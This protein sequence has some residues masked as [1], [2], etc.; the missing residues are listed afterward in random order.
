MRRKLYAR[1]SLKVSLTVIACVG[2]VLALAAALYLAKPAICARRTLAKMET[3]RIGGTT[4]VEAE[5]IAGQ[6]EAKPTGVCSPAE[7]EWVYGIS[8]LPVPDW[9]R[10][11]GEVFRV[12]IHVKGGLVD[13]TQLQYWIGFGSIVSGVTVSEKV[14]WPSNR[15]DTRSIKAEG[16]RGPNSFISVRMTPSDSAEIRKQ[17]TSFNWNCFWQ[18]Q[19]CNNA[20]ELMPAG[21]W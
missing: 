20:H 10:G 18:Y 8:N 21:D 2:F 4:F 17:Y 5:Q 7:C 15:K 1:M 14:D 19:G 9:W 3:I 11:Q 13:W 16:W 12:Y 6:I